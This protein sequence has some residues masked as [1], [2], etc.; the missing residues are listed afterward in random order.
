LNPRLFSFH[1]SSWSRDRKAKNRLG[2]FQTPPDPFR[3]PLGN[4]Q[5]GQ[6]DDDPEGKEKKLRDALADLRV[7]HPQTTMQIQNQ[8]G[9]ADIEGK[10]D[11]RS[12]CR[13]AVRKPVSLEPVALTTLTA[14]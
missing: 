9:K 6:Y 1:S 12:A 4:P 13:T 10:G 7:R 2:P 14:W 8:P 11:L 3:Q 5:N